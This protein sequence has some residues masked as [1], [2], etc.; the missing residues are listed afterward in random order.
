[1]QNSKNEIKIVENLYRFPNNNAGES[2]NSGV[3]DNK[4][5]KKRS[6]YG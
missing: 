5:S 1:M 4:G 3:E 6:K 2:P